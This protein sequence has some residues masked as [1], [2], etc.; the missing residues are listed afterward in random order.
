MIHLARVLQDRR[1]RLCGAFSIANH[2]C[3]GGRSY[4]GMATLRANWSITCLAGVITLSLSGSV[5]AQ[6]V[7]LWTLGADNNAYSDFQQEDKLTNEG[8]GSADVLDDDYYLAGTYP[9][10]IGELLADEPTTDPRGDS[11]S[12]LTPPIVGMERAVWQAYTNSCCDDNNLRI[13]FNLPDD[14]RPDDRFVFV[15]EPLYLGRGSGLVDSRYGLAVNFNG[16]EIIP[17][18][19][20]TSADER[21]PISSPAFTAADVAASGG[22]GGDNV[23]ELI[24]IPDSNQTGGGYWMI[25][26]FHRLLIEP[27]GIALSPDGIYAQDFDIALGAD[28][29]VT[30]IALPTGWIAGDASSLAKNVTTEPFP[31]E[32]SFGRSSTFNVRGEN[33][34]DRALAVGVSNGSDHRLLQL[35]ADVTGDDASSFQLQFDVEAW[36][37]RDGIRVGNRVL[38]GPDD[39]G[40]AAFNVT[41]DLDTGDGFAQLIDLG[42]VT[43]GPTLQPVFE[44]IVDGNADANRISF[45]SGVVSASIPEGSQLRVRWEADT[46]AE[47]AGW[48]FGLDN[49]FLSLFGGGSQTGDF[50]DDGVLNSSDIDLLMH[51]VAAGTHD[52]TFDL[53]S[54]GAVDDGDR[55]E[56]L[57]LAANAREIA[58]PFLVGDSNLDGSV[59]STDLN[60]LA[61]N[62]RGAT[63]D[64]TGGNFAGAGVNSADLN[65]LALNW[66]QT[67]AAPSQAVPEP[68]CLALVAMVGLA[69]AARREP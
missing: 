19:T 20:I 2:Q 54:D 25:F 39:P 53:D 13:H 56:W 44:G 62:W 40:E 34:S 69:L 64:W 24:G 6:L 36:D 7:E 67:A 16:H 28:G 47:T 51:E 55:D 59:D 37:A 35:L 66:R 15:T 61:L 3:H 49:V 22:A 29:S 60:A 50:N 32:S 65:A 8:P 9:E 31:V 14:L 18:T 46:D 12:G 10:P 30:G 27:K 45:D 68:G 52:I 41:V 58:G 42:T 23:I 5:K 43:T 26:D 1:G 11:N 48:V 21:V 33:D 38:S 4:S 57:T 17:R 63:N